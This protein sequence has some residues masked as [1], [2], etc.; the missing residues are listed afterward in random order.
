[1]TI[2][3][4][5]NNGK[6]IELSSGER[7]AAGGLLSFYSGK[8]LQQLRTDAPNLII[9]D[10]HSFYGANSKLQAKSV[11]KGYEK[12][13][14]WH[15]D[16]SS[17]K[18]TTSNIIGWLGDGKAQVQ[19]H[20]RFDSSQKQYFLSFMLQRVFHPHILDAVVDMASG[21]SLELLPYLFALY[22]QRAFHQHGPYKEY[23][24]FNCN[25]SR[26]RGRIDV[27]R[28]LKENLPFQGKISYQLR[29]H[30]YDN[31][32]TRLIRCC[33]HYLSHNPIYSKALQR[34]RDG[35]PELRAMQQHL[36]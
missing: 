35:S 15:Y 17:G 22:A 33:W 16:N 18:L 34:A 21:S 25:D 3:T 9:V 24:S 19:I 20:S 32:I 8:S 14:V 23:H 1:M 29:E 2:T 13:P 10:A 12:D 11:E 36:E 30:S 31:R 4:S 5:D 28:Q 6:G 7:G 26:P 27:A